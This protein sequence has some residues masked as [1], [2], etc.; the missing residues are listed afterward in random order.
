MVAPYVKIAVLVGVLNIELTVTLGEVEN[1]EARV[2]VNVPRQTDS[3]GCCSK[4]GS[5]ETTGVIH[6]KANTRIRSMM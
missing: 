5:C 4:R 3:V 6:I 2:E 1:V